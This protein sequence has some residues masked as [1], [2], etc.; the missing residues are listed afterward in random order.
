MVII[1]TLSF[2]LASTIML[3]I[4]NVHIYV[5]RAVFNATTNW[6]IQVKVW[7]CISISPQWAQ[8]LF[9]DKKIP[10]VI[11]YRA[12]FVL[13]FLFVSVFIPYRYKVIAYT[14]CRLLVFR[15]IC[16][17]YYWHV[18]VGNGFIL[19]LYYAL[20]PAATDQNTGRI[21]WMWIT[22]SPDCWLMKPVVGHHKW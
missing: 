14:I 18:K 7:G 11:S 3:C 22:F 17:F 15:F 12:C 13:S 5:H 6:S 1:V 4:F 20:Y 21:L 10:N 8:E 19:Y 2:L 16:F 9:V